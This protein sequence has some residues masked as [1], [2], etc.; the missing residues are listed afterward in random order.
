MEEVD[1]LAFL[2]RVQ[3]GQDFGIDVHGLGIL[4]CHEKARH[5][6]HPMVEKWHGQSED[7]LHLF[8]HG[9]RSYG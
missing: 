5:Q 2:F 8:S 1:E 9:D 4:I 7:E 3:A 6:G